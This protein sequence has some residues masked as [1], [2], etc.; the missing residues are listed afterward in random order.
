[1]SENLS[2]EE[3]VPTRYFKKV[4]KATSNTPGYIENVLFT[5]PQLPIHNRDEVLG[6]DREFVEILPN[7]NFWTMT[8]NQDI[9]DKDHELWDSIISHWD[10]ELNDV[11]IEKLP[12]LT[13]DDI[14]LRR[15][16]MLAGTDNQFNIDTPDP[17]KTLWIEHRQL[18]RDLPEREIAANRT[19][20]TV[21]WN[22]YL[23]PYPETA[24]AGLSNE[25]AAKCVWYVPATTSKK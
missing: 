12:P 24:R 15:N 25:E 4:W 17:L 2:T 18:L 13:W 22:D 1:M 19:P 9:I 7:S 11:V 3:T 16:A 8:F 10:W 20:D 14:R 23:P 5:E 21:F 6:P